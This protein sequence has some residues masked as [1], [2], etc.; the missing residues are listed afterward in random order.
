M[1]SLLLFVLSQHL[2]LA[3][4]ISWFS[5]QEVTLTTRDLIY[6]LPWLRGARA[7]SPPPWLHTEYLHI[8]VC[9][10]GQT[11]GPSFVTE[12]Q[13]FPSASLCGPFLLCQRG[14]LLLSCKGPSRFTPSRF[15]IM[16]DA[17]RCHLPY[18]TA[19]KTHFFPPK[20]ASK[21]SPASYMRS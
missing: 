1:V 3:R 21:N 19:Y 4:T 17:C 8:P 6:C 12:H 7:G 15:C 10:L 18:L 2:L 14:A 5:P 16:C 9:S 20:N 13:N 11:A